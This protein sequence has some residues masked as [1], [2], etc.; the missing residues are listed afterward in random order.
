MH[1]LVDGDD[2][3]KLPLSFIIMLTGGAIL[4]VLRSTVGAPESVEFNQ[5]LSRAVVGCSR[6][7]FTE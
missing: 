7:S 3:V 5:L 1:L 2:D 4:V 6:L